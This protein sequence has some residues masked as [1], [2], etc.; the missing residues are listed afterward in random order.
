[1]DDSFLLESIAVDSLGVARFIDFRFRTLKGDVDV[2]ARD[3]AAVRESVGPLVDSL[4]SQQDCVMS[5]QLRVFD[6][7]LTAVCLRPAHLVYDKQ[8]YL[9]PANP[10]S[11]VSAVVFRQIA[12]WERSPTVSCGCGLLAFRSPTGAPV[13]PTVCGLSWLSYIGDKHGNTHPTAG[14]ETSYEWMIARPS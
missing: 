8:G 2:H 5:R 6:S 13:L 10:A 7:P 11:P 3:N 1:M 9:I 4:G 14:S 12:W